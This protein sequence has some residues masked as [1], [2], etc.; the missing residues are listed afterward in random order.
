MGFFRTNK[1]GSKKTNVIKPPKG[2]KITKV[3]KKR[4]YAFV[5]AVKGKPKRNTVKRHKRRSSYSIFG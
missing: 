1:T 3:S 2:Y 5:D 4:G